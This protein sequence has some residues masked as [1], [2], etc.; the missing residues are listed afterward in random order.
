MKAAKL[1]TIAVIAWVFV[2]AGGCATL[3]PTELQQV[4]RARQEAAEVLDSFARAVAD[5]DVE[6]AMALVAPGVK[7]MVS[8][9]MWLESYTGYELDAEGAVSRKGPRAWLERQVALTVPGTNA[10]GMELRDRFVLVRTPTG[11]ALNDFSLR[12]PI[13]GEEVDLPESDREQVRQKVKLFFN[14]LKEG[15][16][17]EIFVSLPNEMGAQ[18]RTGTR[19]MWQKIFGGGGEVYCILDDLKRVLE[20]DVQNWP[21]PDRYLPT[22][23]VSALEVAVTTCGPGAESTRR[24]T[25]ASRYF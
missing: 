17:T 18:Y 5:D 20:F 19:S 9:A 23:Y 21:D 6:A 4:E 8:K 25:F 11:W 7:N 16:A 3:T 2:L 12:E 15:R 1:L 10:K 13:P 14:R 24:T 22:A